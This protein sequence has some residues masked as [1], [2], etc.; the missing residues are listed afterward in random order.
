MKNFSSMSGCLFL[1]L[2]SPVGTNEDS[3]SLAGCTSLFSAP[4][5]SSSFSR[6]SFSSSIMKILPLSFLRQTR[7]EEEEKNTHTTF[8]KNH[9]RE[10]RE[11]RW[12]DLIDSIFFFM[13]EKHDNLP[14]GQ[15]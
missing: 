14:I 1:F 13:M 11:H 9:S 8:D 12:I 2:R 5:S 7:R 6:L 4:F 10:R 15:M 3:H